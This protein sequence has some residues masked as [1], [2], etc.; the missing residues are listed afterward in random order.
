MDIHVG[1]IDTHEYQKTKEHVSKSIKK[2]SDKKFIKLF[3]E[4]LD[5]IIAIF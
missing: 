3:S 5:I 2:N 4:E 1:K